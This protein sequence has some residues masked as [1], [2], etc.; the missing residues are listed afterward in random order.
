MTVNYWLVY[1]CRA[2]WRAS[3]PYPEAGDARQAARL[4]LSGADAYVVPGGILEGLARMWR[5]TES[6]Q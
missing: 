4:L 1:R 2:R 6:E 3:G 5:H